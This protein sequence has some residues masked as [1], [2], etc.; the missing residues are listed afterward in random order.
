M[1][2]YTQEQL[3][4]AYEQGWIVAS[5]WANRTDLIAD[6]DS[7]AFEKERDERLKKFPPCAIGVEFNL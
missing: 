1:N 6:T 4:A 5:N 3:E 2:V 7:P